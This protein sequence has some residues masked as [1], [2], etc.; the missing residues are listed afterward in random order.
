MFRRTLARAFG[1]VFK[2][3]KFCIPH[4]EKMHKG[5][6]D[7][8]LLGKRLMAVADGVGGWIRA[9]VDPGLYSKGLLSAME[10]HAAKDDKLDCGISLMRK[11]YDDNKSIMGSSTCCIATL[12]EDS[13]CC[14]ANV[15]DSGALIYR[16]SSKKILFKSEEQ[17]HDFNF[18]KQLGTNSDDV[19]EHA[20]VTKVKLEKG[21]LVF[22][23][24]DGIFDNL[25]DENIIEIISGDKPE[26]AKM[27]LAERNIHLVKTAFQHSLDPTYE[28]PFAVREKEWVKK[29][30]R[31]GVL[32]SRPRSFMRSFVGGKSDDITAVLAVVV[33]EEVE[34]QISRK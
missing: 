25:F 15:G 8:M 31:G 22:L 21:D 13:T 20:D 16:P 12:T 6:E 5:G 24:T 33:D 3:S 30:F 14:I 9:G 32:R 17:C 18:P 7:A 4:P 11:A 27:D 26:F 28:S 10:K 19:P 1:N 23:A 34:D 2:G 29:K